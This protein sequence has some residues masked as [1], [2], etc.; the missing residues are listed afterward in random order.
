[1]KSR[2]AVLICLAAIVA[3]VGLLP[4]QVDAQ[5]LR[6]SVWL[7]TTL[8]HA[9]WNPDGTLLAVSGYDGIRIFDSN[10]LP[11]GSVFGGEGHWFAVEWSP[12]GQQFAASNS[13]I[14]TT[15]IW[16]WDAQA[17]VAQPLQT[18]PN[19][20]AFEGVSGAYWSPDGSKLVTIGTYTTP[21]AYY[22][23]YQVWDMATGERLNVLPY[24]MGFRTPR[25]AWSPDGS[26]IAG[27]GIQHCLPSVPEGQC[28]PGGEVVFVTSVTNPDDIWFAR[29][30]LVPTDL[31]WSETTIA[32]AAGGYIRTFDPVTGTQ[33][34]SIDTSQSYRLR[35]SPDGRYLAAMSGRG[36]VDILAIDGATYQVVA[37]FET[38]AGDLPNS[39][40]W[41][42]NNF[43]T[44]TT[45]DGLIEVWDVS[46]RVEATP[47]TPAPTFTP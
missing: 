14:G 28:L 10:L 37:S 36:V 30:P 43:I 16:S 45:D 34:L 21:A 4:A 46:T 20:D 12:D 11:V 39:F 40:E 8:T 17:G 13:S 7:P 33:L 26:R 2:Y 23:V 18:L 41:G 32:V 19:L 3:F 24:Q 29:V 1:M 5:T 27:G 31:D 38:N 47:A 15:F 25:V 9:S 35:W 42:S 22:G 6:N 44:I